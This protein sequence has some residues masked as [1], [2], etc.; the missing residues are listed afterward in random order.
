MALMWAIVLI[1]SI[2]RNLPFSGLDETKCVVQQ[3][4]SAL[5][6]H[7]I[8][9]SVVGVQ[10]IQPMPNLT[11][12]QLDALR[13]DI[14]AHGVQTPVTKDQHGRIIDGH[15]R[16]ALAT[17]LG[18]DYPVATITVADD[19][20]AWNR[21]VALNSARRHMTREQVREL[22]ASE[23]LRCPEDSDR[24]ISRRVACSPTT[25][26][27]VRADVRREAVELTARIRSWHIQ[28]VDSVTAEAIL[29]HRKGFGW[30]PA[31][32]TLERITRAVL[33]EEDPI[34]F[35]DD[36]WGPLLGRDFDDIRAF[37]CEDAC[38]VCTEFD[39]QWRRDHPGTVRRWV[40]V[41]N[42][43]GPSPSDTTT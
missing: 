24:A 36:L 18:I 42:L 4:I 43:D 25:V 21:A 29:L 10:P 19:R 39:R 22:I 20:D 12:E 40:E 23:I 38:G 41:S 1:R 37:E 2:G 8:G 34:F 32:D 26:G 30:I 14:L 16:A 3:H 31:G 33:A 28:L 5:L 35:T 27:S 13:A 15:N 9:P 7:S 11:A 17:E 6:V